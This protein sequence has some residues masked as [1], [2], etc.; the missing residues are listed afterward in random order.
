VIFVRHSQSANNAIFSEPGMTA[1]LYGMQRLPDPEISSLG[2]SQAE[3]LGQFLADGAEQL[4]STSILRRIWPIARVYVS[5][6]LRTLQTLQNAIG[7]ASWSPTPEV[8]ANFFETGGL[9]NHN[10]AAVNGAGLGRPQILELVPGI[11]IPG[12]VTEAGWYSL[13]SKESFMQT[14]GRVASVAASLRQLAAASEQIDG[15]VM[16]VGHGNFSFLLLE[17]ILGHDAWAAATGSQMSVDARGCTR[18]DS[19]TGMTMIE[20]QT[21]GRAQIVF[22]NRTDHLPADLVTS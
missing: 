17:E 6:M 14:K 12:D 22:G 7:S 16:L 11:G 3:A 5:P 15:S 19:H 13:A 4:P 8:W 20:I 21:D 1:E 2:V 18:M 10:G 9:F